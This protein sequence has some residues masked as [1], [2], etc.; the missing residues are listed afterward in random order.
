MFHVDTECSARQPRAKTFVS[1]VAAAFLARTLGQF[2]TACSDRW[3]GCP[4]DLP[5]VTLLCPSPVSRAVDHWVGDSR[6]APDDSSLV[7][8]SLCVFLQ[9][10]SCWWNCIVGEQR[11]QALLHPHHWLNWIG[12]TWGQQISPDSSGSPQKPLLDNGWAWWRFQKPRHTHPMSA[13]LI[14]CP[15]S[16]KQKRRHTPWM[17][18]NTRFRWIYQDLL[19][20]LLCELVSTSAWNP[21]QR[22]STCSQDQAPGGTAVQKPL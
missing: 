20:K 15:S 18:G 10:S 2:L 8:S 7:G 21:G 17:R 4:T 12:H 5:H 22:R 9:G 1:H 11:G 14:S 13:M 16:G 3:K 19:Q 6:L